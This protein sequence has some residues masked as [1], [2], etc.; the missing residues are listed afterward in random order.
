MFLKNL[1]IF[2]SVNYIRDQML[3][4]REL[5]GLSSMGESNLNEFLKFL[6]TLSTFK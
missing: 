6:K 3:P 1:P 5:W 2:N 4:R